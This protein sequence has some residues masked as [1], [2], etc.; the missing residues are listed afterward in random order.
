MKVKLKSVVVSFCIK[1]RVSQVY[2]PLKKA[3]ALK[4]KTNVTSWLPKQTCVSELPPP[5]PKRPKRL[6]AGKKVV[7]PKPKKQLPALK[8]GPH[9]LLRQKKRRR[10]L[11]GA[12]KRPL[13][14]LATLVLLV[15]CAL[16]HVPP[17]A[18]R[19]PHR[20]PKPPHLRQKVLQLHL[21][22]I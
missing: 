4:P 12:K 13:R 6:T 20:Q 7:K 18:R 5:M 15:R 19:R 1:K 14:V 3:S 11:Q 8:H 10:L 22:R 21:A 9:L 17:N 2:Q 16:Y